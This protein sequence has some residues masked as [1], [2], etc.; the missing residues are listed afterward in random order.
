MV[1]RKLLYNE[2]RRGVPAENL[3]RIEE[4]LREPFEEHELPELM[5]Q[6]KVDNQRDLEIGAGSARFVAGRCAAGIQ[7]AS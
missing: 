6:L 2:F 1:D 5:K 3:P 7:R 4:N